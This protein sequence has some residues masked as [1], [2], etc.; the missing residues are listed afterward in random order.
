MLSVSLFSDAMRPGWEQE[1]RV[2]RH[3]VSVSRRQQATARLANRFR[4]GCVI[5]VL[6]VGVLAGVAYG[7]A[8]QSPGCNG[9]RANPAD[10]D[11]CSMCCRS[12]SACALCC[13]VHFMGQFRPD[14]EAFCED[15]FGT[16]AYQSSESEI[17]RCIVHFACLSASSF[18]RVVLDG[19]R[20]TRRRRRRLAPT[21]GSIR[22]HFE[23]RRIVRSWCYSS[24]RIVRPTPRY[25]STG[26]V[27]WRGATTRC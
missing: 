10:T 3:I 16:G 7:Q 18:W 6:V 13:S 23:Y 20:P 21:P 2:G 5:A 26:A 17:D 27:G 25:C 19:R 4:M 11:D 8:R 15:E 12:K 9:S 14:G 24:A 1:V 22:C